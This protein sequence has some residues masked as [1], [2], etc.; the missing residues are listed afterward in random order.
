MSLT[1]PLPRSFRPL[2]GLAGG[3]SQ[4][5]LG[6][7]LR[8]TA[9][10]PLHRERWTTPD[11]D[12]LDLDFAPDPDP[13]SPLLVVLHGLEGNARRG[14]CMESYR[15]AAAAGMA[16]V[17]L[18]FRACSGEPNLRARA[19]HSGET[20]DLRFVLETL[21]ERFADRPLAA[22]GF[23]LGGN[24]LLKYLGE[25]GAEEPAGV[26]A[27][28]VVSVPYDLSAGA[29]RLQD[30]FM[31]RTLYSRYF[32]RSL[33][34]KVEQKAHL[35]DDDAML[36]GVRA[37]RTIRAFDDALT[38]PLHGFLDAADYYHRSSSARYLD[39]IRVPT[40]LLHAMDDPFL[41]RSAV[42]LRAMQNNPSLHPVITE[43]GGHVGFVSGRLARPRFWAEESAA[44]FLAGVARSP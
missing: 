14:Y 44:R 8:S 1:P 18:N 26:R 31:G 2:A 15:A 29:D 23:S 13:E 11:G 5:I 39:G 30:T 40:L 27:A 16:A 33:L 4:T 28:A 20:E 21:R 24:V 35:V 6:K 34:E 12:F 10:P 22:L 43:Q 25:H 17:G 19:Y 41:P 3:H 37:A 9:E 42:P 7:L 38:A 32:L 36:E